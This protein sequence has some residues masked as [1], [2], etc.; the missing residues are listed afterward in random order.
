MREREKN[1]DEQKIV[2]LPLSSFS[3]FFL[4]S[5]LNERSFDRVALLLTRVPFLVDDIKRMF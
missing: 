3:S 2:L 4:P 1:E 5:F